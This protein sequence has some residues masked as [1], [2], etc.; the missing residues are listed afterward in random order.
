VTTRRRPGTPT[1]V[2]ARVALVLD[3]VNAGG[4][5]AVTDIARATGLPKATELF[6]TWP[7]RRT[8]GPPRGCSGTGAPS[9]PQ[10]TPLRP[11]GQL[12]SPCGLTC[13]DVR[14][15]KL[16]VSRLVIELLDHE[17]LAHEEHLVRSGRRITRPLDDS[18]VPGTRPATEAP[19]TS[20]PASR[21]DGHQRTVPA[22]P[23]HW[24][25]RPLRRA[26][27]WCGPI[28]GGPAPPRSSDPGSSRP[29]PARPR[30]RR[31]EG[32]AGLGRG[33]CTED[34]D[35]RRAHHTGPTSHHRSTAAP[36]G[37]EPRPGAGH[38]PRAQ[39]VR[40]LRR[41]PRSA[42]PARRRTSCRRHLRHLQ[43]ARRR[44]APQRS[45]GPQHCPH[46]RT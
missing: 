21:S 7:D 29:S 5:L 13:E 1:S 39:R 9:R 26:R 3:A 24:P 22:A 23:G 46:P 8:I 34:R 10:V 28:P 19:K 25:R 41:M 2:I 15:E 12:P 27:P 20:P 31:G 17:F 4:A 11:T 18:P 36:G 6:P 35:R 30:N 44:P 33:G 32:D 45:G 37:V 14:L 43:P 40:A 38:R 42:R 16:T